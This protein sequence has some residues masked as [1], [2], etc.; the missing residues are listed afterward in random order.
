VDLSKDP[1]PL[2]KPDSQLVMSLLAKGL[3]L[4]LLP[5]LAWPGRIPSAPA[6]SAPGL[7]TDATAARIR[8]RAKLAA[9][10]KV[11]RTEAT[12]RSLVSQPSGVPGRLAADR[13]RHAGVA[14]AD[15]GRAEASGPAGRHRKRARGRHARGEA[16]LL[17]TPLNGGL[18]RE[19]AISAAIAAPASISRVARR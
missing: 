4:M 7:R 17:V 3:P 18:D 6:E 14:A 2:Q 16:R 5:D 10:T 19:L 11:V 1:E 13:G 12:R 9:V 8:E 15:E